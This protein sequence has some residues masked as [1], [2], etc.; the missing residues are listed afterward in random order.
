MTVM[1]KRGVLAIHMTVVM[2]PGI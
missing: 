1:Y 2:T